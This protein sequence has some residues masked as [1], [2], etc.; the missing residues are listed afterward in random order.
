MYLSV[1]WEMVNSITW[2]YTAVNVPNLRSPCVMA[3]YYDVQRWTN[4]IFCDKTS[5][6][7]QRQL[8]R[9]WCECGLYFCRNLD[10]DALARSAAAG[11]PE[12]F[13]LG[14]RAVPYRGLLGPIDAL[15]KDKPDLIIVPTG[16]LIALPFR[17]LV[18]EQS[19]VAV[20]KLENISTYR[21]VY[22]ATHG[23]SP[24]R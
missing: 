10:V 21:V 8:L 11:R 14:R 12:L 2:A 17:L 15:I 4:I 9:D 13:D 22:F 24:A 20:P 18:T 16:A 3:L 19:A 1:I 5:W 23:S 7:N 6:V